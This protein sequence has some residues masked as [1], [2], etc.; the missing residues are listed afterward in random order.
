MWDACVTKTLRERRVG[1]EAPRGAGLAEPARRAD[2]ALDR[3]VLELVPCL[4]DSS[5]HLLHGV[6]ELNAEATE[7]VTLPRVVLRVHARLHLLVVDDTHAKRLLCFRRVEGGACFLDL[8]QQLLPVAKVVAEAVEDV[9]GFEV[10]ERLEL[11]PFAD[12]LLQLLNLGLN[13]GERPL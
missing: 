3:L 8:R 13:E 10:P 7:D 1:G 4:C 5:V 2:E 11:E 12:V 6:A 9:F